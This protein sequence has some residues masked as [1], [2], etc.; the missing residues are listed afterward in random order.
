ML[1]IKS[2]AW[3]GSIRYEPVVTLRKVD[4]SAAVM[5]FGQVFKITLTSMT[6]RHSGRSE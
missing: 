2:G 5:C 3:C 6:S 4:M 1:G